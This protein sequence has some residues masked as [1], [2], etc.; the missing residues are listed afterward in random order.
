MLTWLWRAG[1]LYLIVT[2][3]VFNLVLVSAATYLLSSRISEHW[4]WKQLVRWWEGPVDR[5]V[6][7]VVEPVAGGAANPGYAQLPKGKWVKIHQQHPDDAIRFSRQRHAGSAFDRRR[8]EL[9]L[10]GSDTHGRN[11][12]NAVYRF[13]MSRLE[14]SRSYAPDGPETY[15]VNGEG[16]PVAGVNG[17]H[18]WAM[19]TFDAVMYD[20]RQDALIV[21]SYPKHLKP[22]RFGNWMEEVWEGI[23]KHPTWIFDLKSRQ[24]R[25]ARGKA[26]DFFPY[27]TAYDSTR[28]V[29]V[30]FQ[31][32]GIY[33]FRDGSWN[34]VGRETYYAYHTNAVYDSGRQ[35]FVIYGANDKR[36]AIYVYVPGD[37]RAREMP[38][39]GVRPPGT[40]HQPMAYHDRLGRVVVLID[41]ADRAST[42]TYDPSADRWQRIEGAD[43][44]FPV[45]MDYMMQYDP[46]N[47]LLVLVASPEGEETSVWVL[48]L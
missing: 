20:Q 17:D 9:L 15:R 25:Y 2:G 48:R 32:Y 38:T 43:F 11:W 36:D 19:H 23:R 40:Q 34:K 31:P 21:A 16:I 4:R 26:V 13:S 6:T 14:W 8:G 45:G 30:G 3:L 46:V 7:A 37:D 35:R 22:G 10:F 24:W 41:G 27:A 1:R 28:G 42:W 39:P 5:A 44:P 33:E 29:A 12:D 18:P 47:D